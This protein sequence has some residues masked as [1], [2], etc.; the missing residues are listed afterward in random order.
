L[1]TAAQLF[2]PFSIAVDSSGNL[3]IADYGNNR[4]RK[5]DTSGTITTVAGNGTTIFS[6]D[7][8]PATSASLNLPASIAFDNAGNLLIADSLH[9]R[10]RK[11]IAPAIMQLPRTGQ[12]T[13]YDTS[14]AVVACAGTGQDGDELAGKP[15]NLPR[16]TDNG[17]QTMT[18]RVSGLVW[19]KNANAPGP[20]TCSPGT[21]KNW[22]GALDYVKCLNNNNYLN[23]NDW[24]LPNRIELESL[25]DRQQGQQ[26]SPATALMGLGFINVQ[27]ADYYTSTTFN[28]QPTHVAWH[29]SMADGSVTVF[30]SWKSS[31]GYNVWPV[32]G[33]EWG[34]V[35]QL[36]RTGQTK[37]YDSA[38]AVIPCT[39]TGQDGDKLMGAAWP[40][41]RFVDNGNGAVTDNLTGLIWLKNATCF[42]ATSWVDALNDSNNLFGNNYQC[43]L[44]D[45]SMAGD[46][47]LPNINEL[48]SLMDMQ[49][50]YP[51][52]SRSAPFSN[53]SGYQFWSSSTVTG[54]TNTAWSINMAFG[55][56]DNVDKTTI[57]APFSNNVWPVR[58]G[59][60]G[61]SV[62][63]VFPASIN[64]GSVPVLGNANQIFTISNNGTTSRMHINAMSFS[65]TNAGEF[66]LNVGDGTGGTCGSTI[67]IIAPG[68][69]C[70]VIV[71][72]NPAST[73]SKT[74]NLRI[75]SSDVN[76]PYKDIPLSGTAITGIVV[77]PS[78]GPNGTIIPNTNPV[79][80]ASGSTASF[81]LA[82]ATGYLPASIVGG[83]CPLGSFNGNTYTT[84]AITADCS[85]SF[86]FVP[87]SV[88]I[89]T[90]TSGNGI[91]TCTPGTTV[92]YGTSVSCTAT[93]AV[94]NHITLIA[95]DGTGQAITNPTTFTYPFGNVTANH[96][97]NAI[98]AIDTY[99]VT[100]SVTGGNGSITP[101]SSTVNSGSSVTL[102]INPALCYNL[103]TLTDN[104]SNVLGNVSSGT[105]TYTINNTV[106]N[107]AVSGSF[108]ADTV[109]PVLV[110]STLPDGSYTNNS[111]LNISG[112]VTDNCG[113][114]ELTINGAVVPVNS[115]GTFSY[116]LVLQIGPNLITTIA[117][118]LIGN[119]TTDNRTITLDQ[120]AP[121]LVI[122]TPADNSKTAN[123]LSTVS[124]TVD[125]TS[126]VTVELSNS[127]GITRQT[128]T[129][130]G[131]SF[132]TDLILAPGTNSIL[133]TA[134]DLAG[135]PSSGNRTV[136]YD[137]QAPSLAITFPAQ[138]IS[139]N[140]TTLTIRGT[141]S[142]PYTA[143]TVSITMDGQTYTPAVVDGQFEQTVTFTTAKS[144][145]IVV[146]ATNEA[147]TSTTV[148]R[149]VILLTSGSYLGELIK[150]LLESGAITLK[151]ADTLRDSLAKALDAYS[152]KTNGDQMMN[153]FINDVNAAENSGKISAETANLLVNAA[154]N[155]IASQG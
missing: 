108:V 155:V 117:T 39:N 64:Y 61:N 34:G 16:F 59:Q 138:D 139:T 78:V 9:A 89:T 36:P 102:F 20:L 97:M 56:V 68:A 15:W 3:F 22:Q 23:K 29:V 149:N 77:T 90:T 4:I 105:Y 106:S 10:I 145:A 130:N 18:D 119:P 113:F 8:G 70:T 60:F 71:S 43:S 93:S 32:R 66:S 5:I 118:D 79:T 24:R 109:P 37:C 133:V 92:A 107:H 73:G 98:F 142:D 132:T 48:E 42:G 151:T 44:N 30:G 84:G 33:G 137:D 112:S 110:I 91:I 88:T 49:S 26:A 124:G 87:M 14:G 65:G 67:P 116:A 25:I 76:T 122:I 52:I 123:P 141:A 131:T 41:P 46:W 96:T 55:S 148:Q 135:N 13:C 144:Y 54:G 12:T 63:A 53:V 147:G 150:A 69:N 50:S 27:S 7:G 127:L 128:A 95:V 80:V 100:A 94:G 75:G 35:V 99:T 136:I 115:D 111:V 45:G 152:N 11:V 134:T 47:R 121:K 17:D 40:M 114:K 143:V 81:T 129:M 83:T 21:I 146:T 101:A 82:P 74:A 38:D 31:G 126:I 2:N 104:N 85:V 125:E 28:G 120:T 58:G 86:S 62:F 19:T 140:Q 51:V 153:R 57:N 1:A 6:G 154:N 103:A 72:F